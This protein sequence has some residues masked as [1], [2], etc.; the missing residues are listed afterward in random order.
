LHNSSSQAGNNPSVV[1]AGADAAGQFGL[2]VLDDLARAFA[3]A[4]LR[5]LINARIASITA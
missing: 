1:C 3:L 2:I 5:V 4:P